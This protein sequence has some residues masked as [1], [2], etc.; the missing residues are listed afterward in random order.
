MLPVNGWQ[1]S[2]LTQSIRYSVCVGGQQRAKHIAY[3]FRKHKAHGYDDIQIA[4]AT[5]MGQD[6][7]PHLA[8]MGFC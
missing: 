2:T 5:L 7:T 3:I 6:L 4:G 8:H 1:I